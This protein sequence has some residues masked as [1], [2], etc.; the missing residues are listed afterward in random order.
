MSLLGRIN[1]L[2]MASAHHAID[3]AEN[4]EIMLK[5]VIR[6]MDRNI[7]DARAAVVSAVAG[8]KQLATQVEHHRRAAAE[9]E[10]KAESALKAGRE[11]L[12]RQALARNVDH[13]RIAAELDGAHASAS[14]TCAR[15]KLQL[16]A[17]IAKRADAARRKE[18]LVARQ[19][20]AQARSRLTRSLSALSVG[21][22]S[23]ERLERMQARV[24]EMEAQAAAISDVL[25]VQPQPEKDIAELEAAAQVDAALARMKARLFGQ[26]PSA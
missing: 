23:S 14:D 7:H 15:L 9:L 8:E 16:D 24:G 1:D 25:E 19:R 17:L 22:T 6:D 12:A 3:Q 10:R 18:V 13:A 21:D 5:Q 26:D 4:P 11:D 2:F 20:T